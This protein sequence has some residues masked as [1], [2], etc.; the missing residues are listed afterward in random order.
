MAEQVA[1]EVKEFEEFI[2]ALR[3]K[4]DEEALATLLG[5]LIDGRIEKM[6]QTS[7]GPSY[8]PQRRAR[9]TGSYDLFDLGLKKMGAS[10][11]DSEEFE[12]MADELYLCSHILGC[13]PRELNMWQDWQAVTSDLRKAMDT[14][15]AGE[16]EEW[17]PTEFSRDLI[18]KVRLELKVAALHQ[19]INI[20]TPTYRMPIEGADAVAYLV[21]EST[22]DEATK[23]KAS[24]PGTKRVSFDAQKLASR[25][26]FSEEI[27][28]DSVIPILPYLR[29]KII[30][31]LAVAQET[32]TVNGDNSSTHQDSDVTD[33][34]DA[35]KAWKGYRK[36]AL[37]A[38][39][40]DL[41]TFS[42]TNI[43]AI[44]KAM[45]KYGVAINELAWVTGI[46]CWN[47]MLDLTEV[48]TVDKYGP[49]ATIL[50]GELGKFD[51]IPIVISEYVR[52]D[53]NAS[54]VYDG[55][56]TTKTILLLVR[57]NGFL[58]GDRRQMKIKSAE[59]IETDQTQIV[60]TQRLDFE[61]QYDTDTERIMG[62]GYNI[63]S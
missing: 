48:R 41:G 7:E 25:V 15:T 57:R 27:S 43:R 39:K 42:T 5:G 11:G 31:A 26:L 51:N 35:R 28:E 17:I 54:G 16:G 49:K 1:P 62:L 3:E 9:F 53:L 50:T 2:K 58:Y 56:T 63:T 29:G 61:A 14:A 32:A 10:P 38:A 6:Q 34:L 60:V 46:A 52:E 45:Q 24:T 8:V 18:E 19:R 22:S 47:K 33:P 23:I 4:K 40:V 12:K 13:D 44:R 20:P 36:L 21:P 59:I 37:T 55:A 30:T